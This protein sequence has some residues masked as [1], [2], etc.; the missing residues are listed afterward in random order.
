MFHLPLVVSCLCRPT[1]GLWPCLEP[2][3]MPQPDPAAR[4]LPRD[5]RSASTSDILSSGTMT[6][7]RG[8][9]MRSF[10]LACVA[11]I[12]IAAIGAGIL[13]FVQEPVGVAFTT[14]G[15]RL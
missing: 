4:S 9:G 1:I 14:E 11:A 2:G 10:I 12:V 5:R 3:A 6:P 8:T 15:V 13:N 7:D